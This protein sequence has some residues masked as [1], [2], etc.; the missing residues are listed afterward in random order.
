MTLQATTT[1]QERFSPTSARVWVNSLTTHTDAQKHPHAAWRDVPEKTG[2][3][4]LRTERDRGRRAAVKWGW[5]PSQATQS[6]QMAHVLIVSEEQIGLP[7]D[8]V[9]STTPWPAL[10]QR[11]TTEPTRP[12]VGVTSTTPW[13]AL[14]QRPEPDARAWRGVFSPTCRR[15]VLFSQT[16]K[17]RTATLPKWKPRI[18]IDRRTLVRAEDE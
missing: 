5:R 18:T 14:W 16:V 2:V 17:R 4:L 8:S 7:G 6:Y 10:W 12:R 3:I 1:T 9:T 11:W 15:E 13:P